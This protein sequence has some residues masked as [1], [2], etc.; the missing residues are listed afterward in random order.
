MPPVFGPVSP[1]PT[2][3]WSCAVPKG[4][5]GRAVAEAE[6]ARLLAGQELLDHDFGAGAA[7][8][9]VEAVVDRR[10]RL[11]LGH[12]DGHALA[13]G[14]PVGLDDDR[15]ALLADIGLRRLGVGEAAIGGGRDVLARAEILG[16]ALRA[17]ELRRSLR[18]AEDLDAGRTQIVGD[19]RR[20]AAPPARPRRGRST[21]RWQ[22][23][24]TA[25]WS[26]IS[27]AT[28]SASLAMPGLP[29][30]A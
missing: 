23:A 7:E 21:C 28:S 30:A 9:A 12:R 20:P 17:L 25:A 19:A 10:K 11:G 24:A 3:L 22:K 2:R 15:R 16:E 13:G 8:R 29:G 26:A 27:S 5:R 6:E 4:K 14:K 18:R 1:S